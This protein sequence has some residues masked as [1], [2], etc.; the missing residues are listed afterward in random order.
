MPPFEKKNIF[1]FINKIIANAML[2]LL[3]LRCL[4]IDGC[5]RSQT[6]HNG[7]LQHLPFEGLLRT[8]HREHYGHLE[9]NFHSLVQQGNE[10][11]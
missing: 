6:D 1:K 3:P 10:Y 2:C 9:S 5:I 4:D 8:A 11:I 7:I